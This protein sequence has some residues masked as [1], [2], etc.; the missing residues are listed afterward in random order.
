MRQPKKLK[1]RWKP[2]TGA[3]CALYGLRMK[4]E[5][6]PSLSPKLPALVARGRKS[7]L[8]LIEF[9]TVSIRNRNTQGPL[10]RSWAGAR[11]QIERVEFETD[12]CTTGGLAFAAS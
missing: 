1:P 3:K 6:I 2:N 5:I 9:F 11:A 4:S 10:V 12:I 8:A 7:R